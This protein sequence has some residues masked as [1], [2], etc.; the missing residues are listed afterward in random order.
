MKNIIIVGTGGL[1]NDL[2]MYLQAQ[3]NTSLSVKGV[4]VDV[5]EDHQK[6]EINE[7]YLGKIKEYILDENDLLLIAIGENP[8]RK[9]IIRYFKEKKATFFTIIHPTAIIHP[10]SKIKEGCIIGPF[11]IIGSNATIGENTFIN[12]YCNVGHDANL[13]QGCIMYPYSMVGGKC[14]IG[15]NVVL[16]TR[17]TIA[18]KLE[19]GNNCIVSAHTFVNKN[20]EYDTFVFNSIKQVK[21]KI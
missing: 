14:N 9:N 2:Y 4:L 1:A 21:K 11:S 16:S 10:S 3:V 15:E 5:E 13:E 6:S 17:S 7:Q 18:P 8:G 20:I 12:K 19:I